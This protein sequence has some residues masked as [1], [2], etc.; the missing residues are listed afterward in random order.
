MHVQTKSADV[1]E[2]ATACAMPYVQC[3]TRCPRSH[4]RR[5]AEE[6]WGAKGSVDGFGRRALQVCADVL[7][8]ADGAHTVEQ[9][10][11]AL[12]QGYF[13]LGSSSLGQ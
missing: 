4:R 8:A 3:N 13:V 9:N 10:G 12:C 5:Q 11:T 6:M 7:A 1:I 2:I